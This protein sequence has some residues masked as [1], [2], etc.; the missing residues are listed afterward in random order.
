LPPADADVM[1]E[2]LRVDAAKIAAARVDM[3]QSQDRVRRSLRAEPFDVDAMRAA[4]A[5][6]HDA[7]ARFDAAIHD[8]LASAASRMSIAGRDAI[9]DWPAPRVIARQVQQSAGSGGAAPSIG[10]DRQ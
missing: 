10:G 2:E 5:A 6:N 8:M 1:R 3:R 7:H 9:A 4:M